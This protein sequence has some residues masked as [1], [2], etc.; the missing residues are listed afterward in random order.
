MHYIPLQPTGKGLEYFNHLVSWFVCLLASQ[1]TQQKSYK[2]Y[3]GHIPIQG[4]I[5][6]WLIFL[7]DLGYETLFVQ[8][9]SGNIWSLWST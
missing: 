2:L 5:Y 8:L 3:Q 6:L 4:G 7:K 9:F 1:H